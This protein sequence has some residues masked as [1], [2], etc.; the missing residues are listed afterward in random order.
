[1]DELT[2]PIDKVLHEVKNI[3][4]LSKS[5]ERRKKNIKD[6]T[7]NMTEDFLKEDQGLKEL[8]KPANYISR[9]D[10]VNIF[11]YEDFS[12]Y[13]YD[14][15]CDDL[16]IGFNLMRDVMLRK[17]ICLNDIGKIIQSN[18][19]EIQTTIDSLKHL[20]LGIIPILYGD[21]I[22]ELIKRNGENSGFHFFTNRGI[23]FASFKD[24][25]DIR[26]F[27]LDNYFRCFRRDYV[28]DKEYVV[29]F[30]ESEDNDMRRQKELITN[31]FIKMDLYTAIFI[32]RIT[33]LFFKD[34]YLT[35]PDK[36]K[37][38]YSF[39]LRQVSGKDCDGDHYDS[40]TI[41]MY[42]DKGVS[43]RNKKYKFIK[44]FKLS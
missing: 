28:P 2:D 10:V 30:V 40:P 36:Q 9:K 4:L 19:Q 20:K 27:D 12:K 8:F 37:S 26:K 22:D 23:D 14:F 1:M 15:F 16:S 11:G 5:M 33:G 44:I 29:M 41:L 3:R 25:K 32:Y 31:G 13:V 18:R 42:Y 6:V 35:N 39:S 24:R 38:E 43:K 17:F 34:I 7:D 21:R